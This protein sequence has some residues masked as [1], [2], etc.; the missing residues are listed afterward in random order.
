MLPLLLTPF[1]LGIMGIFFVIGSFVDPRSSQATA[2]TVGI[3]FLIMA[4]VLAY[5]LFVVIPKCAKK[6]QEAEEKRERQKKLDEQIRLENEQKQLA[7]KEGLEKY[8]AMEVEERSK[9]YRAAEAMRELGMIVQ[10]S[11]YQEKE[12]NWAIR[13]GLANGLGGPGAGIASA[14]DAMQENA[15]IQAENAARREWGANQNAAYR[16]LANETVRKATKVTPMEQLQKTYEVVLSWSPHTLLSLLSLSNEKINIDPK[17]GAVNVS[18][19][20]S[21][22]DRSFCID[23]SLRAKLYT[24]EGKCAGCAYLIFPKL[25]TTG[26][27]GTLSG[28]CACPKPSDHYTVRFEPMDLWELAPKGKPA[29]GNNDNLTP[30]EHRQYV[31]KCEEQFLAEM[32]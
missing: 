16:S 25:G 14:V 31:S 24:N 13:G 1:A 26:F 5:I 29:S 11:V 15:R 22:K 27:Y 28:I 10:Q 7:H 8:H 23:G 9:S 6:N 32:S 4:G 19:T 21:Q 20:W 12:T 30:T 17:T 3:V 18:V 2:L